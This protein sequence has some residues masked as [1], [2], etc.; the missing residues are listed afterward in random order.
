MGFTERNSVRTSMVRRDKYP[1]QEALRESQ[2]RAIKQKFAKSPEEVFKWMKD[3]DME[4]PLIL[5]PATGAGTEGVRKC[6]NVEDVVHAFMAECTSGKVNICGVQNAGLIAQEFLQGPEYV[7]DSISCGKG[8][9]AVVAFWKYQKMADL[10]YEYAK[11]ME[12]SGEVQDS[13]RFYIEKVLDAVG[14]YY[15][16]SHAEVIMTKDGPCLVEVGA[17]MHG[18]HGPS[19]MQDATGFGHH[20]FLADLTLGGKAAERMREW[21]ILD[22]TYRYDLVQHA[23]YGQL[24]NRPEWQLTGTLQEEIGA[25]IPGINE[26]VVSDAQAGLNFVNLHPAAIRQFHAVAHKGDQLQITSDLLSSPGVF[27]VINESEQE[28]EAAIQAVRKAERAILAHA[29]GG[30]DIDTDA[31]TGTDTDTASDYLSESDLKL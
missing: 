4:F 11:L 6:N 15:G 26:K 14:I 23:Y 8:K 16:A 5:K 25:F 20:E 1:M 12:S 17:R 27:L 2:L 13:L 9:H 21:V 7:V 22:K 10:T 31:A 18:G 28:C 3:A 19:V 29:I 24:N 30:T